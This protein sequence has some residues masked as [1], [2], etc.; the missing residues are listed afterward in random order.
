MS[1]TCY[2]GMVFVGGSGGEDG[3]RGFIAAFSENNG[4]Q[5]WKHY[6]IP[7][8]GEGWV[9]PHECGGGTVYNAPTIDKK[10]GILY[11]GTGSPAP[12]LLGEKRPGANLY[13]SS[14]IAIKASTGEMLWY[15]QE[16]PHNVYGYGAEQ[17]VTIFNTIVNGK[18][19][20]AVAE[21]GKDGYL[22]ILNAKT[23]ETLFPPVA[24]VKQEH[25]TPTR[26]GTVECPGPI[27]AVGFSPLSFDPETGNLYVGALEVCE[28]VTVTNCALH[29]LRGEEEFCGN[30]KLAPGWKPRG[31]FTAVNVTNGQIA[32][33]H[34]MTS[35]ILAG[36]TATT[37]GIVFTGDQHGTVYAFDAKSGKTLW[38][39]NV[40]LAMSTPFEVY[41]VNG[42]EYVLGSIGG[43]ALTEGL[44]L[45]ALGA[46]IVA[47][48]LG[49]HQLPGS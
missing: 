2:H 16:V 27:G 29:G 25:S 46:E 40:N 11:M 20:E 14:I 6:T 5:L 8:R 45:G 9:C 47:L 26:K 1:P 18:T 41:S 23:G 15:H 30:Q 48:K 34:K 44:Q 24:L 4:T 21:A 43:S 49:G 12:T 10:T 32:W 31:T 7:K 36:A 22:Y 42:Q 38:Q 13:T 19:V 33:Q 39:G 37:G 28:L 35:P 3:V 17:P